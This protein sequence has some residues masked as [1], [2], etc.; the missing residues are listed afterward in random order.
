MAAYDIADKSTIITGASAASVRR[1]RARWS[2]AEP[3]SASSFLSQQ[4]VD[5]VASSLPAD[6]VLALAGDVTRI[7]QMTAV[8]DTAVERFSKVN[9]V[10][11]NAGIANDPPTFLTDG[12]NLHP[13][14]YRDAG[15]CFRGGPP[16]WTP[17]GRTRYARKTR[18]RPGG[19]LRSTT[20]SLRVS[21]S[22]RLSEMSA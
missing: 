21:S 13:R 22:Q 15:S 9:I 8:T 11:A 20:G 14:V 17:S 2:S 16:I 7:E 19:P 12:D 18:E 1:P 10:S 6:R 4:A 5:A 3:K